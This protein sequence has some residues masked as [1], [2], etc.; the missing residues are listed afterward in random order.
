VTARANGEALIIAQA[1]AGRDTVPV[2]VEQY[3]AR[4]APL[5]RPGPVA[6]GIPFL[7]PLVVVVQD[8]GGAVA[9]KAGTV[10]QLELV[11]NPSGGTLSG[12]LSRHAPAGTAA[13]DQ[14]VIDASG[15]G[16]TIAATAPFDTVATEPFTVLAGP[17]LVRFHNVASDSVGALFDGDGG[18][19]LNDLRSVGADS[20]ATIVLRRAS[21]S[22]EVI[23][24][25]RGRPP[26]LF[27]DVPWTDGV[28]T[29]DLAFRVPI[30]IP[31]T[32]WIVAGTYQSLAARAA[33]AVFKTVEI[34]DAERMGVE[35][36]VV[37]VVDATADP[38][39]ATVLRTTTCQQQAAAESGIGKTAGEINIYANQHITV[40]TLP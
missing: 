27:P 7:S 22:N 13:F 24:F 11:S 36:G 3:P 26:I 2:R 6:A 30:P 34:W 28:D 10:V 8:S 14:L 20:V 23:A 25:T 9:V 35:F 17:D 31:V 16:Y 19:A 29:F 4:F 40:E 12:T 15:Q 18:R 1:A 32:I 21:G 39:V 33:D 5:S 38:D 37:T